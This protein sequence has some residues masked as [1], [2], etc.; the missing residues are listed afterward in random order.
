[1]NRSLISQ[2][3]DMTEHLINQDYKG[4]KYINLSKIKLI[5]HK[6][7]TPIKLKNNKTLIPTFKKYNS[8]IKRSTKFVFI[9]SKKNQII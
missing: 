9:E 6:N 1:M 2:K 4:K 5:T 3:L 7:I 8:T